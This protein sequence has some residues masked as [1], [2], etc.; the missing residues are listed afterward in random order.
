MDKCYELYSGWRF[1]WWIVLST[2]EP[3][4][5]QTH[6]TRKG[7]KDR[8]RV[9]FLLDAAVSCSRRPLKIR[10]LVWEVKY[11]D[12]RM[13]NNVKSNLIFRSIKLIKKDLP[14]LYSTAFWC[15]HP[16]LWSFVWRRH[17]WGAQNVRRKLTETSV[18][19]FFCKYANS[20]FH[21]THKDS[22]NNYSETRN[23]STK[24]QKI[25]NVRLWASGNV[26]KPHKGF[27]GRL[28]NAAS[29]KSLKI[30]PSF[31]AKRRTLSNRKFIQIKLFGCC[32][33]SWK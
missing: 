24:F 8:W 16:N 31:M 11:W 29:P 32:N 33:A 10:D 5:Y 13:L 17:V 7:C 4:A 23:V 9:T 19:E 30:Q 22:S 26:F 14:A 2:F 3:K 20:S 15:L 28:L 18:F 6:V 12:L 27:P 25:S 1:I 21:S